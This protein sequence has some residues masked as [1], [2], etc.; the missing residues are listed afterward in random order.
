MRAKKL[1]GALAAIVMC[2]GLSSVVVQAEE[3]AQEISYEEF[4]SH[5]EHGDQI[6]IIAEV[7]DTQVGE[8]QFTCSID[9]AEHHVTVPVQD[10]NGFITQQDEGNQTDDGNQ[11]DENDQPDAREQTEA[12]TEIILSQ[13]SLRIPVLETEYTV[14]ASVNEDA[15]DKSLTWIS[16]DPDVVSVKSSDSAGVVLVAH[17]EGNATITVS[18]N[19]GSVKELPVTVAN[20]LN[21]LHEDPSGQLDGTYYYSNG[22][23]QDVT[24]VR[25]INGIWYN[26]VD[27]KIVGNTVAKNSN[28]W[29]YIDAGGTV[30]FDYNGIAS[31]ANGNWVI[32]NGKVDFSANA[33]TKITGESG[34]W[35][36]RKGEV[37]TDYTGIAKNSKGWWRI[38][39]GQVDFD[40]NSVEKNENGWFYIRGGKVDFDY[41]GVAKNSKGW[42]R[43]VKG[44]VDFKCNSVEKNENGWWYI[45]KG[46]VDF[47]Y[48]GVAKNSKGWWRIVKGKVD[49][50]CNSVEKNDK[51]WWYIRKGKVDFGY[52]GVAKNKNGWW[53]I[54]DGKVNFGFTGIATNENGAWYIR[55]GKVD[56][57]YTGIVKWQG[58]TYDVKNGKTAVYTNYNMYEK[59]KNL[60]SNTNWLILVDTHAN[61]VAIYRGSKGNWAE[62]KYW[63]C[64]TGASGSPTVKGSFTVGSKGRAFGSGYTCWYY[65]QF[66]GNYLFHSILY[67]PG[68][69]TSVQD[70]RLGINASHGCVRLALGNAKWIYDNIPRGTKVYVY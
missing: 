27:G 2:F 42:W 26:L 57:D 51:G 69:M 33:V 8:Y 45:R 16:S 48:T 70:G 22:V 31:N 1:T 6:D 20:L 23:L 56:F 30:D 13:D 36:V 60:S 41:T 40:C 55:K 10:A 9:G 11:P 59:A 66:Y 54:E 62:Q 67:N 43:I 29:W 14:S 18:A 53:R 47:D 65:T 63:S 3:P 39:D 35:Y 38:V 17:K 19:D 50:N 52:T 64:T 12:V 58:R 68:S 25:K 32:R 4:Q 21:G 24:D 49:F 44:K 34:W 7:S 5:Q 37:Q 46:K 61:K 15:T 28:G